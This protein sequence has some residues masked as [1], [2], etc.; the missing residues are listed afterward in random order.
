MPRRS[1]SHAWIDRDAPLVDACHHLSVS[2]PVA[3]DIEFARFNTYYPKAALYQLASA[4]EVFLMDATAIEDFEPLASL[5]ASTEILKVVHGAGEDIEVIRT[6]L[7]VSPQQMFDTQTAASIV[8]LGWSMGYATLANLCLGLEI[9]KHEQRSDWLARPLSRSQ[10]RYAL[11]DVAYLLEL[12]A[13]LD[14]KLRAMN[15][16]AWFDEEMSKQLMREEIPPEQYY[17]KLAGARQLRPKQRS[18]LRAL[19]DWRE[20]E[21]RRR[22]QPRQWVVRDEHLLRFARKDRLRKSLLRE[23]LPENIVERYGGA[24]KSAFARGA[25]SEPPADMD[26]A[27]TME[28]R[29]IVKEI[30]AEV[31]NIALDIK[32]PPE[33]LATRREIERCVREWLS[34]NQVPTYISGWRRPFLSPIFDE[35]LGEIPAE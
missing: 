12:H 6:H 5:I 15:R 11:Q 29:Q 4:R 20:R 3:L 18:V 26:D 10:L 23:C 24:L 17:L 1:P 19:C 34:K 35:K 32:V 14:D 27:P 33:L 9:S 22:D 8:G 13:A 28:S 30:L 21:A 25:A 16:R 2:S 31:V 7:G